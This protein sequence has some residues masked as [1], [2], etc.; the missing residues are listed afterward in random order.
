MAG[1]HAN[2]DNT[3]FGA[4]TL[5]AAVTEIRR[6]QAQMAAIERDKA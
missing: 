1:D 4:A 3:G 5:L 6:L 2:H